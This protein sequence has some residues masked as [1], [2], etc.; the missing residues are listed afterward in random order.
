M[1]IFL[2]G[3]ETWFEKFRLAGIRN[4]LF[5]FYYLRKQKSISKLLEAMYELKA[6]GEAKGK[7]VRYFLDSGAFTY[8]NDRGKKP[9]PAVY[10]K[11]F[12]SFVER[13]GDLW[14][15]VAELDIDE[16]DDENLLVSTEQVEL[17]RDELYEV[18]GA[19]DIIPCWHENRGQ[20]KWREYCKD[21]R[22]P[23]LA[24]SSRVPNLGQK[25]RLC[26]VAHA[27]GKKVHGFAETKL[28]TDAKYLKCDTVDS[29]TWL[30]A[31]KFGGMFIFQGN[32]FRILDHKHKA[33][34]RLFRN[35]F[36]NIGVDPN[37]VCQDE[38]KL[39][40]DSPEYTQYQD[41]LTKASLI[42]WRNLAERYEQFG[43]NHGKAGHPKPR[44]SGRQDGYEEG[45]PVQDLVDG[46]PAR[47]R[48]RSIEVVGTRGTSPDPSGYSGGEPDGLSSQPGDGSTDCGQAGEQ[49]AGAARDP[50]IGGS[51]PAAQDLLGGAFMGR[52]FRLKKDGSGGLI[53]ASAPEVPVEQKLSKQTPDKVPAYPADFRLVELDPGDPGTWYDK[54]GHVLCF[55]Y[56]PPLGAAE[57]LARAHAVMGTIGRAV[58]CFTCGSRETEKWHPTL[59]PPQKTLAVFRPQCDRCNR[60]PKVLQNGR[61]KIGDMMPAVPTI[62]ARNDKNL[63]LGGEA[64]ELAATLRSA[65]YQ[66]VN[67]DA[68]KQA[69]QNI[70]RCPH[71]SSNLSHCMFQC[72]R[73]GGRWVARQGHDPSHLEPMTPEEL[74]RAYELE[75]NKTAAKEVAK[76]D[77]IRDNHDA[78][79]MDASTV[80]EAT[81]CGNCGHEKWAHAPNGQGLCA[82]CLHNGTRCSVYQEAAHVGSKI[83]LHHEAAK[84]VGNVEVIGGKTSSSDGKSTSTITIEGKK[85][86][87]VMN[88]ASLISHSADVEAG[89]VE[90]RKLP[91]LGCSNCA[92]Q[93]EC[94]EYEEGSVCYYTDT[95][96][97]LPV[98]NLEAHKAQIE[99]LVEQD[100]ERTIRAVLQERLSAGGMIDPRVTAQM[101]AYMA[102]LQQLRDLY[103][104]RPASVTASLTVTGQNP[105]SSTRGILSRMFGAPTAGD[106]E[107]DNIP[108]RDALSLEAPKDRS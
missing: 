77:T 68:I 83:P 42:A 17:W 13:T 100:W 103:S 33:D 16:S 61:L 94:P 37:I 105:A 38:T 80:P 46:P 9:D 82:D 85:H 40:P 20:D 26:A 5:S 2:A 54:A 72:E 104:I 36:K 19:A 1:L 75:I 99:W 24:F 106:F 87:P 15:L 21:P 70:A 7:P 101:D 79:V 53:P 52:V 59:Y 4:M 23:H 60:E 93:G 89:L 107:I 67:G 64:K 27:H 8:Q 65:G 6:V 74:T 96:R 84:E 98:R 45:S 10:F 86:L 55:P 102:R 95:F 92:M 35:Y 29:S 58:G 50:P 44:D 78:P 48:R 76:Q 57:N 73:C 47:T 31:T 41:E 69:I 56:S 62:R 11:E 3:A 14:N 34:R 43:G 63:E 30:R 91:Q 97:K 18:R 32:R 25:N 81:K 51:Q 71:G 66:V 108:A 22:F 28:Q 49:A 12:K 90:M 88:Q 39:E